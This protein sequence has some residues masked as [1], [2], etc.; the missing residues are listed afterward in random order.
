VFFDGD[1]GPYLQQPHLSQ[2]AKDIHVPAEGGSMV[3]EPF[4]G[5]DETCPFC[6]EKYGT[7]RPL[8][9]RIAFAGVVFVA[10]ARLL[11][12][13]PSAFVETKLTHCWSFDRA[14]ILG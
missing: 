1:S 7:E 12:G 3:L 8:Q 5:K 13:Q 9:N 10:A 14:E 2:S 6:P 11:G 4:D